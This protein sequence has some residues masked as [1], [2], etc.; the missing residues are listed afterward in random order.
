[1]AKLG[2]EGALGVVWEKRK[3][4]NRSQLLE[5]CG[6]HPNLKRSIQALEQEPPCNL[7]SAFLILCQNVKIKVEKTKELAE[8]LVP[9]LSYFNVSLA[10]CKFL[11]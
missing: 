2:K 1:M 6:Q 5:L 11:S 9:V 3:L 4:W 7:Q 10:H 8:Q